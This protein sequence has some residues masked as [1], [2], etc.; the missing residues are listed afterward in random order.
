M[1]LVNLASDGQ[2]C[3]RPVRYAVMRSGDHSVV[4][5]TM[6]SSNDVTEASNSCPN[7]APLDSGHYLRPQNW[8]QL[9]ATRAILRGLWPAFKSLTDKKA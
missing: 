7:P 4:R 5:R 9:L 3:P 6:V 8:H 1:T 2:I